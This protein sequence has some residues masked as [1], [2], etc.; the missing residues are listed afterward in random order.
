M[1]THPEIERMRKSLVGWLRV[2]GIL[3]AAAEGKVQG[4]NAE[5]AARALSRYTPT[6]KALGKELYRLMREVD[7]EVNLP[8]DPVELAKLALSNTSKEAKVTATGIWPLLIVV[9]GVVLLVASVVNRLSE[10][11]EEERYLECVEAGACPP[12]TNW[13]KVVFWGVLAAGVWFA[14]TRTNVFNRFKKA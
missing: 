3:A 2:R 9:G 13:G 14:W 5:R 4:A 8:E 1:G 6:E 12:P 7:S 11:A 10:K